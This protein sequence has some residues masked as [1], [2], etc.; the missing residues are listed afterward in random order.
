VV[1]TLVVN[2]ITDLTYALLDKRVKL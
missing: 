2:L 1:G